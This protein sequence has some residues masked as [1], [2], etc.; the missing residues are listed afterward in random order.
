MADAPGQLSG[1][2]RVAPL[3]RSAEPEAGA[4]DLHAVLEVVEEQ[5]RIRPILSVVAAV[6]LGFLL[7]RLLRS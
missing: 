3:D 1:T 5:V 7:G 4:L 6:T 2:P